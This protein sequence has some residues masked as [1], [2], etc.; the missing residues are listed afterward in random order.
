[1]HFPPPHTVYIF[2]GIKHFSNIKTKRIAKNVHSESGGR[3]VPQIFRRF[4]MNR[5]TNQ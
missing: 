5:L 3:G 2:L 1:M 4:C